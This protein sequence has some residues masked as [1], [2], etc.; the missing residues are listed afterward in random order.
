MVD[1][2]GSFSHHSVGF[3]MLSSC[4][5]PWTGS[6]MLTCRVYGDSCMHP[7]GVHPH[8]ESPKLT[9]HWGWGVGDA[10]FHCFISRKQNPTKIVDFRANNMIFKNIAIFFGN[11]SKNLKS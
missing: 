10:S 2:A 5:L 9:C 6:S 8:G 1:Q 4:R 11:F 3:Q 7:G